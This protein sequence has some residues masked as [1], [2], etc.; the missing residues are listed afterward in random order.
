MA[1]N[2]VINNATMTI[3]DPTND[4]ITFIRKHLTYVDKSK[5]YQLRRMARSVWARNS[6]AYA[7][8]QAQVKGTLYEEGNNSIILSS[9]FI[10]MLSREFKT[11]SISS[12]TRCDTG[13]KVALPW[14]N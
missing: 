9:C 14:V 13:K 3:T 10:D 1:N 7:A 11:L 12:D 5:Q 4:V 6:P 2:I 8:L